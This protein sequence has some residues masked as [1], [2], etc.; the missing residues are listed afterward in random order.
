M[1]KSLNKYKKS[2]WINTSLSNRYRAK[3]SVRK[4][5]SAI[6]VVQALATINQIK[7]SMSLDKAGKAAAIASIALKAFVAASKTLKGNGG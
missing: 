5:Q 6:V 7:F 3:V 4:M 1:N 2:R